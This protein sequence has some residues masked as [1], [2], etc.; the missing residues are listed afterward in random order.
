MCTLMPGS[1]SPP[2]LTEQHTWCGLHRPPDVSDV[3]AS[4]I[5]GLFWPKLPDDSVKLHPKVHQPRVWIAWSCMA[6]SC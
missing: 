6:L 3:T 5:S 2:L 4:I 1:R